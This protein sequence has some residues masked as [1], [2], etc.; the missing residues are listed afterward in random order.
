MAAVA[1]AQREGDWQCPNE[2][3]INHQQFP[4]YFV[5]GT[6]VN[7][8]K[9]G[10]G[11]SAKRP[12][13]WCCPNA[14]C[15]NHLNTVYGT[16]DMCTKCGTPKPMLGARGVQMAA[17]SMTMQA[18]AAGMVGVAG[19]PGTAQGARPGDWH[20]PNQSCKNYTD[21][22]VYGSKTTCPLCGTPKPQEPDGPPPPMVLHMPAV[23]R[24]PPPQPMM[25]TSTPSMPSVFSQP[26]VYSQAEVYGQSEVYSQS[27]P[28]ASARPSGPAGHPGDWHC[29]NTA[30]K[31]HT[32]NVVY[33]SKT[34]CPLCNRPKPFA[35][36]TVAMTR[37][38]GDW[39][40]PNPA[41]K[42][43][44]NGVYGTKPVCSMCGSPNPNLHAGVVPDMSGRI[45]SRSPRRTLL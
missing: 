34:H 44:T 40:C 22:V 7:C 38:P 33:A 10:T 25:Q 24:P 8:P 42:N 18:P 27:M 41:C 9:C 11:K 36:V 19:G 26:E 35:G 45:R 13:D 43:H 15:I 21:N 17:V 32:D 16:K 2:L 20:C 23:V 29:A 12:G 1:S 6:K 14:L 37:R 4:K 3:C 39:Q 31:N 5:Y 28:T 30:C